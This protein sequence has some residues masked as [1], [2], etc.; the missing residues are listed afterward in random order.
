MASPKSETAFVNKFLHTA[1]VN[2]TN[3]NKT[4]I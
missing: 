1:A 2:T 4:I 3:G